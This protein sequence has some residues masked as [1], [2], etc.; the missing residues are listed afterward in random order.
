MVDFAPS[1]T[2]LFIISITYLI[3]AAL[4]LFFKLRGQPVPV[5]VIAGW[6][7][8][9][10]AGVALS[11]MLAEGRP[12]VWVGL[13]VALVPWMGFSLVTD[14]RHRMF[15]IAATDVAALVGIGW[16]MMRVYGASIR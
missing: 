12:W 14:L 7:V 16:A 2:V 15:W 3:S 5:W 11:P 13:V 4:L 1:R 8:T 9:G 10:L 6:V